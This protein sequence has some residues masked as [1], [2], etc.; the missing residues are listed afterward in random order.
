MSSTTLMIVIT[1]PKESEFVQDSGF[2]VKPQQKFWLSSPNHVLRSEH[3]PTP[4]Y[5]IHEAMPEISR[6]SELVIEEIIQE[7]WTI[8]DEIEYENS[9]STINT[10]DDLDYEIDYQIWKAEQWSDF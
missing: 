10:D 4:R 1:S 6:I 8:E 5:V 7:E 9:I 2:F 3:I